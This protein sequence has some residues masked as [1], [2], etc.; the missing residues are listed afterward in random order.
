[1]PHPERASEEIHRY[2]L[3]GCGAIGV[4]LVLYLVARVFWKRSRGGPS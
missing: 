3:I 2:T 1:M 4:I